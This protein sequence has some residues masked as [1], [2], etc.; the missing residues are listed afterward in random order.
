[1][2][3]LKN[4]MVFIRGKFVVTKPSD[5]E[6]LD[7]LSM[8]FDSLNSAFYQITSSIFNFDLPIF[9]VNQKRNIKNSILIFC[10]ESNKEYG[11]EK[12]YQLTFFEGLLYV[13]EIV[14]QEDSDEVTLLGK[15]NKL[16]ENP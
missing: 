15:F 14:P 12:R 13:E 9:K 6:E 5:G 2:Q 3:I 1:M 8:R 10:G 4:R 7:T 16:S 11:A